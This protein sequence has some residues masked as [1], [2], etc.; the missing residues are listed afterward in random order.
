MAIH[1]DWGTLWH[2]LKQGIDVHHLFFSEKSNLRVRYQGPNGSKPQAVMPLLW[3][4]TRKL[5][6]QKPHTNM[7][8]QQWG[9]NFF[10]IFQECWA[11]KTWWESFQSCSHRREWVTPKYMPDHCQQSPRARACSAPEPTLLGHRGFQVGIAD[12]ASRGFLKLETRVK[13]VLEPFF[14]FP[15]F[16]GPVLEP[17]FNFAGFS[18]PVLEPFFNFPGFLGPVLEPFFN[19]P[20][21][22]GPVLEPFFNFPGFLGH[23]S[24]SGSLSTGAESK[25]WSASRSFRVWSAIR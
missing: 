7:R 6:V 16:L 20:G 15:G 22:L 11:R 8:I 4:A 3:E 21:F 2:H 23:P 25:P 9:V 10:Q 14:N 12:S 17:F 24:K 19:F 18:G 1:V 13:P 5:E